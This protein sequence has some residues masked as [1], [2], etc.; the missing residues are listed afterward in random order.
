ML[1]DK[2]KYFIFILLM[3]ALQACESHEPVK[4]IKSDSGLLFG[5]DLL[6]SSHLDL[7]KGKRIAIV[8]NKASVLS[9]GTSLLDT[10]LRIDSVKIGAVF[11]P[12]HGYNIDVTAGTTV[13]DSAIGNVSFYSLYGKNK[14]PDPEMLNGIDIILFDLQD[15]GTRFYTYISTLFYVMQAAGEN[16][17]PI[18]VLDR[19]DPIGGSQIDGPVLELG[20]KS[21]VG[22]ASIPVI[23]GMTA[24]ELAQ[25]FAGE[26]M[27][28]AE[29]ELKIIRMRNWRRDSFFNDY[30]LKWISPSPNIPDFETALVYPAAAF[31][32]GTNISEGRGTYKPFK[33]IGAPF[34]NSADLINDLNQFHHEGL[35]IT[36][37]SFIPAS[38]PGKAENPKFKSETCNGIFLSVTNAADFKPMVFS[39]QLLY[40]LHKLYP[41]KFKFKPAVFDNLMGESS[42]RK[43]IIADK[44]TEEIT[45]SWKQDIEKFIKIRA[46][47]LL[48]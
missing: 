27:F 17:I 34:I 22:I 31:L 2:L 47:Y 38:L 5:D 44:S 43:M 12:E 33:Q 13:H 3:L 21:F 48:Y 32:E 30:N 15:I 35:T 1:M 37:V 28:T 45:A 24:G 4:P 7:I 8:A 29:P 20:F 41:E 19:P 18:V 36:P 25:L 23:Y 42:T 26:K 46:K 40:S 10:L 39:I 11:T 14:K 9:G 16:N 6:I